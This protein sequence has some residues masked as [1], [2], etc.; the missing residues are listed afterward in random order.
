MNWDDA[1][2]FLAIARSGQMLGAANR[3]NVSQAKLSRRITS[4][5]ESL[6]S[7]LFER[8]TRGCELTG[9]GAAFL[10]VAQRIENEFLQAQSLVR[11]SETTLA[12]TVRIGT[13]DGFGV[14][15]LSPRLHLLQERFPDLNIQLVPAPRSFSLSQREADIAVMI[16]RPVKGRLRTRKLTDY[17]LGI[18]AARSYLKKA[19]TPEKLA[20]LLQHRLVGYVED[21]VFTPEL[22]YAADFLPGWKSSIEI[23]SALG[24]LQAVCSGAGIGVLHEFMAHPHSKD[25]V[26]LFPEQS[27]QRSYWTVWHESMKNTKKVAVVAEFLDQLVR[28]ENHLFLPGSAG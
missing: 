6:G 20:D 23:S 19:G 25:L 24:Q 2:Y 15:F 27:I 8:T 12:G 5:E 11:Q 4:L 18:Y 14:I 16:G 10:E 1:K 7:K 28:Q 21:L 9:D 3:L 17:S 26:R 13:T 22:N